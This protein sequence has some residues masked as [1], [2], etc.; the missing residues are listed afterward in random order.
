MMTAEKPGR[1]NLRGGAFSFSNP[2]NLINLI[3]LI[4]PH[5]PTNHIARSAARS[6]QLQ[7]LATPSIV[8]SR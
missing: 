2:I 5:N 3:N 8:K 7:T 6:R 4:N 1:C